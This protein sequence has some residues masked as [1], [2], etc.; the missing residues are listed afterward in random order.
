MC[1]GQTKQE[2]ERLNRSSRP[3]ASAHYRESMSSHNTEIRNVNNNHIK[4]NSSHQNFLNYPT[5]PTNS[6]SFSP[7]V[8]PGSRSPRR[9][10]LSN[11]HYSH[12]HRAEDKHRRPENAAGGLSQKDLISENQK[13]LA[14]AFF[15]CSPSFFSGSSSRGYHSATKQAGLK[16]NFTDNTSSFHPPLNQPL[17]GNE[18]R[19]PTPHV[20]NYDPPSVKRQA[21][22]Q[23]V[24]SQER[25][26]YMCSESRKSLASSAAQSIKSEPIDSRKSALCLEYSLNKRCYSGVAE[27]KTS[28]VTSQ[29]VSSKPTKHAHFEKFALD[30]KQKEMSSVSEEEININSDLPLNLSTSLNKSGSEL[31]SKRNDSVSHP[32]AALSPPSVFHT[33]L[34]SNSPDRDKNPTSPK[35]LLSF[36]EKQKTG[37][38]R[39]EEERVSETV[40]K[41][42][43]RKSMDKKPSPIDLSAFTTNSETNQNPWPNISAIKGTHSSLLACD[44]RTINTPDLVSRKTP[45]DNNTTF[46][47]QNFPMTPSPMVSTVPA[48]LDYIITVFHNT[49]IFKIKQI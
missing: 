11:H 3:K 48:P 44:G 30:L 1:L 20:P 42:T 10:I 19:S 9:E 34:T 45:S 21:L 17:R 13:A 5:D 6:R 14:E 37:L 32:K 36:E 23:S 35:L 41:E 27:E 24:S 15:N 39:S 2:V 46:F 22:H 4:P 31:E 33:I 40:R 49:F 43:G 38:S 7:H 47:S 8:L 28:V 25:H 18:S 12:H 26:N 16:R 29:I